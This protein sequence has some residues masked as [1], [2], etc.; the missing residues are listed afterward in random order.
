[1]SAV[2]PQLDD[3]DLALLA[4]RET[5]NLWDLGIGFGPAPVERREGEYRGD[6]MLPSEREV[7]DLWDSGLSIQRIAARLDRSADDVGAVVSRYH[8]GP[9]DTDWR[10]MVTSG[11]R[12]LAAAIAATGKVFA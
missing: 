5:L 12:A 7:I 9:E 8:H 10:R 3:H 6:A 4:R 1:M 2:M 11:S